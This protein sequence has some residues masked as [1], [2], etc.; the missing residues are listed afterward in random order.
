MSKKQ[1]KNKTHQ[2]PLNG[3]YTL[4]I[5]ALSIAEGLRIVN[6]VNMGAYAP[7]YLKC[8]KTIKKHVQKIRNKICMHK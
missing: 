4:I 2:T 1:K 3:Q 5:R 8:Q 6:I 7:S